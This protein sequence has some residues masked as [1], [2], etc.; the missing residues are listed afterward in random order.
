MA[1]SARGRFVDNLAAALVSGR[2]DRR[3][4]RQ[5]AGSAVGG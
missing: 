2:W 1:R 3:V 4:M 5:A